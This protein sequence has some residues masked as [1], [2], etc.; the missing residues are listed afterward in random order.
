MTHLDA[1]KADFPPE[2]RGSAMHDLHL[3]QQGRYRRRGAATHLHVSG[4]LDSAACRMAIVGTRQIVASMDTLAQRSVISLRRSCTD[5]GLKP[6]VVSGLALGCDTSAHEASLTLN[7]HTVAVLPAGPGNITPASNRSLAARILASGG[8]LCS[9]HAARAIDRSSFV[10]RDHVQAQMSSALLVIAT[11]HGGGT[12]HATR[13]SLALGR[14]TGVVVPP[15]SERTLPG[16][17]GSQA[18]ADAICSG[19]DSALARALGTDL[20]AARHARTC[21]HVIHNP[22]TLSAFMH[23]A[24]ASHLELRAT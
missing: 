8:A 19:N 1:S 16:Y 23:A 10:L 17:A 12:L 24:I 21:L 13:E 18:I 2:M 20:A 15:R 7:V 4:T 6:S 14:P 3:S 9:E 5:T 22:A 11:S